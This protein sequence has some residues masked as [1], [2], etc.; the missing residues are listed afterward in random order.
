MWTTSCYG[1]KLFKNLNRT[2]DLHLETCR[3]HNF[4]VF[5]LQTHHQKISKF[6][7]QCV[8]F[9][10]T[11]NFRLVSP[12]K[13]ETFSMFKNLYARL[14]SHWEQWTGN[15]NSSSNLN[16]NLSSRLTQGFELL[17]VLVFNFSRYLMRLLY[18]CSAVII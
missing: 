11:A 6:L 15:S 13:L 18:H 9:I 2:G 17:T 10:S 8:W 3:H 14:C 16:E 1:A 5:S 7:F 12:V 4:K